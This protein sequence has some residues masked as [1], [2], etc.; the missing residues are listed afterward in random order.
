MIG[1]LG[2][3]SLLSLPSLLSQESADARGVVLFSSEPGE[4]IDIDAH[5]AEDLTQKAS[6]DVL[7]LMDGDDRCPTVFVLPKR[8]APLLSD[9]PKSKAGEHCLQL[10]NRDRGEAGHAGISSCWTPTRSK[11]GSDP[12]RRSRWTSSHSSAASRMRR[13]A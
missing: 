11:V 8:M 4:F 10:A 12:P 5:V 3:A 7:P 13:I 2:K 9:Q 6:S 1:R